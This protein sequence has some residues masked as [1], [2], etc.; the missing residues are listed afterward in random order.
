MKKCPICKNE[1]F[2]I[3]NDEV[4]CKRCGTVWYKIT[5]FRHTMICPDCG[6]KFRMLMEGALVCT[7]CGFSEDS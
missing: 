6:S 2:I 4:Q 1:E 3:V 7:E 5:D